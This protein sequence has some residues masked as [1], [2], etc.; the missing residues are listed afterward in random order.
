[1][2][3]AV[4]SRHTASSVKR[5]IFDPEEI[6]RET[7]R[8]QREAEA[9]EAA[10]SKLAQYRADE[11]RKEEERKAL[12]EALQ[13]RKEAARI[14]FE[15]EHATRIQKWVNEADSEGLVPRDIIRHVANQ[16]GVTLEEIVGAT[17]SRNVVTAR[18]HAIWEVKRA[19]PMRMSTPRL[20]RTFGGRD[21]TTILHSIRH[22]PAKAARLG[23]PCE[24][25]DKD[26]A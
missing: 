1:M 9:A 15:V 4:S 5:R 8:R 10:T 26:E 18:W 19:F 21:H 13:A 11:L 7:Y 20:G 16:H 25:I 23:I 17:R 24:P 6:S 14:A 12:A 3:F 22:W 2:G